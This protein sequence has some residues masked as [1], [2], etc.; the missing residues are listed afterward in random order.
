[1]SEHT[2]PQQPWQ[3]AGEPEAGGD[4]PTR[5]DESAAVDDTY[6]FATPA[7]APAV[8]AASIGG[9]PPVPPAGAFGPT[10]PPPDGSRR[11]RFPLIAV[12]VVAALVTG[13]VAG[14]GGAAAVLY[15]TGSTGSPVV[16]AAAPVSGST[17]PQQ[18]IS[19]I[20][21]AVSPSVV[22]IK[23][24][25]SQGGD[26][27]SGMVVT[28]DG[29]IV[30][31]NHVVADAANGGGTIT[32][33]F[34]N[35][36]SAKATIVGRDPTTDIAVI[37]VSGVS[38]LQPVTFVSSSSLHVGDTVVAIGNPLGLEGSVTSGIV[39]ALHR[40]VTLGSAQQGGGGRYQQQ[41][42]SETASVA[43]AIQTDAAI[44]PGNSGG[45]LVDAN[46]RVVGITTAIASVG[47]NS[48]SQGGNIGVG[49]A[50]PAETVQSVAN[51]LMAG[52]QP[53]HAN[54]GVSVT[55]TSSGGAQVTQITSGSPAANAGLKAGDVITKVGDT[56]I[57]GADDLGAAVRSHNPGDKVTLTVVRG[58]QTISVPVTLGSATG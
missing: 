40:S 22:S 5:P 19:K 30:T 3:P 9:P 54:L 39:S 49:F 13:G 44:N 2:D 36:K 57:S 33:T 42:P 16:S 56:A 50:I 8:G 34:A 35:G 25:T 6:A 24:T 46:G 43:N 58:G 55:D 31:N 14:A 52:K 21:A 37:K 27:G 41:Q 1:M 20:A 38:G 11:H 18:L 17:T 23:V 7:Y 28:A 29:N 12:A 51:Q 4:A 48:G 10:P 53:S 45:P 47:G 32:V 15:A 26:E